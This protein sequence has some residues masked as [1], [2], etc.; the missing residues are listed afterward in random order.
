MLLLSLPELLSETKTVRVD[1]QL[2]Q[3]ERPDGLGFR[4]VGWKTTTTSLVERW[5]KQLMA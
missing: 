2:D 5:K 1:M 3:D 4:H